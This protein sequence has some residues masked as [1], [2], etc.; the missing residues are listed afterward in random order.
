MACH[1]KWCYQTLGQKEAHPFLQTRDAVIRVK[2]PAS[3]E[4]LS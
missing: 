1:E 3:L 2:A 4:Q